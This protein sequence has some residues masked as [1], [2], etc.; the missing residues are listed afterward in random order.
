[1]EFE[2]MDE[3][4]RYR[5]LAQLV[6]PLVNQHQNL[7]DAEWLKASIMTNLAL[8]ENAIETWKQLLRLKGILK[9]EEF[10]VFREQLFKF[11][12]PWTITEHGYKKSLTHWQ[13]STLTGRFESSYA[14]LAELGRTH[15][16]T[17]GTLLGFVREGN[18][19]EHDDDI[20]FN[21]MIKGDTLE[22][23]VSDMFDFQRELF[24]KGVLDNWEFL[25]TRTFARLKS[26]KIHIDLFPS[27]IMD[28][29]L[30]CW[31]HGIINIDDIL[32][33][34]A[35]E[36]PRGHLNFP[37][38]PE[39]VLECAYGDSWRVPDTTYSYPWNRTFK[40]FKDYQAEYKRQL[41]DNLDIYP[42]RTIK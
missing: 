12:D 13:E 4:E 2:L 34:S 39:A 33:V 6:R 15:F 41:A 38:R 21:V 19:L 18:V 20:D 10:A 3:K 35:Q 17:S 26:E 22:E 24:K 16:L 9:P 1:M 28:G 14:L 8:L 37:A 7:A 31:P 30:Y 29:K 42:G 5:L 23:V 25:P 11:R 27:W 36:T 40:V 32:P